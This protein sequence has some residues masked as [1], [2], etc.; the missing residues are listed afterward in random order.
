MTEKGSSS[1]SLGIPKRSISLP[2]IGN[3]P[4][5]I[6]LN[7]I[8]QAFNI[9]DKNK[10]GLVREENFVEAL[11][12]MDKEMQIAEKYRW[13]Y[14]LDLDGNGTISFEEF[15]A[16][17]NYHTISNLVSWLVANAPQQKTKTTKY[18]G[19]WSPKF[20]LASF[21][22]INVYLE[23][24]I[25][26]NEENPCARFL[27]N[28]KYAI[29]QTILIYN[30]VQMKVFNGA[31][32][33]MIARQASNFFHPDL[34]P[35]TF[36]EQR[37]K[38]LDDLFK[39]RAIVK[40]DCGN[41]VTIVGGFHGTS[42]DKAKIIFQGGFANLATMDNG[43][44][45]K[46]IYFSTYPEYAMQYCENKPKPCLIFCFIILANPFPIIWDDAKSIDELRF[47]G[48]P[49]YR[50]FGCHYVPVIIMVAQI[51]DLPSQM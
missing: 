16:A 24:C 30:P 23:R 7:S 44:F 13:F 1:G 8:F 19:E 40:H 17:K 4:K 31:I 10:E 11:S 46:G 34:S 35:E 38:V 49:N 29:E 25:K 43:W 18:T 37:Q 48:Q 26:V 36:P 20:P 9:L 33:S 32:H 15:T 3:E 22:P 47:F 14:V 45:G 6:K 28:I 2:P 5:I 51:L 50:N 39:L 21:T 41:G 42:Q 27:T 12:L